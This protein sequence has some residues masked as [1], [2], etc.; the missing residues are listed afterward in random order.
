MSAMK[1][2]FHEQTIE[3]V[4]SD[5]I[6]SLRQYLDDESFIYLDVAAVQAHGQMLQ[7]WPLLSEFHRHADEEASAGPA[8][9]APVVAVDVMGDT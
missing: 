7:R 1:N 9:L 8:S 4:L 3:N 2:L 6:A 5:D